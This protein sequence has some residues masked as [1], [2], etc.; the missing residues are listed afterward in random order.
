MLKK[1]LLTLLAL[2]L[3]G[4]IAMFVYLGAPYDPDASP[5]ID[6]EPPDNLVRTIYNP[7]AQNRTTFVEMSSETGGEYTL[8][9]IDLEPGGGNELHYHGQ[10]SE[11]FTAVSGTLGLEIDGE[12]FL[13]EEGERAVAGR[14]QEH[15]FF[16]PGD[17]PVTFEVKIE[18][19]S[20]GFEKALYILYGLANDG[21][22]DDQ[23]I[24]LDPHH[25]GIFVV[26]SDTR[27]STVRGRILGA[28][29]HRFAGRAQRESIE[30]ELIERYYLGVTEPN[31]ES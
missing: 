25:T 1:L 22:T 9:E 2:L 31:E 29:V 18:P 6:M 15:R 3:F 16:N 4:V 8:L 21:L 5:Y 17:E 13:L 11:T 14:Y 28:L 7:I 12:E 20:P 10:F 24:P 30:S 23:T 27:S 26:Y 19:G